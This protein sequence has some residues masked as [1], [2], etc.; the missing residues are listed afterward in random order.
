MGDPL[1]NTSPLWVCC[2]A[3]DWSQAHIWR[4]WVNWRRNPHHAH[5]CFGVLGRRQY[6]STGARYSLSLALRCCRCRLIFS[7]R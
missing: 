7:T 5:Y 2:K 3:I 6:V 1:G 4:M